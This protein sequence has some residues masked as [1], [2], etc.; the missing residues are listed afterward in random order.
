VLIEESVVIELEPGLGVNDSVAD[1][2][3]VGDGLIVLENGVLVNETS[4]VS[5][6]PVPS[7]FVEAVE[8]EAVILLFAGIGKDPS[9]WRDEKM[10]AT[11]IDVLSRSKIEMQDYE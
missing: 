10:V 2:M 1:M 4:D 3:V 9:S 8:S 11:T 6:G 5:V 7:K